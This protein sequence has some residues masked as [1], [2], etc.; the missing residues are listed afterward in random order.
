M[1]GLP[2]RQLSFVS[3]PFRHPPHWTRKR[4]E[5]RER[6][7]VEQ[8]WQPCLLLLAHETVCGHL[9]WSV[10]KLHIITSPSVE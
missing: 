2:P 4:T 10:L 3:Q 5:Y 6:R 9:Q 8:L 1:A 7:F